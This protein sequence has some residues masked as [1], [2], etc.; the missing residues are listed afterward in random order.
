MMM[1]V[2]NFY[3]IYKIKQPQFVYRIVNANMKTTC[4]LYIYILCLANEEENLKT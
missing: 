2:F 3:F 1:F 4:L